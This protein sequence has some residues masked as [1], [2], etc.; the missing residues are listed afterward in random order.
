MQ[1][2]LDGPSADLQFHRQRLGV[3]PTPTLEEFE[4]LEGSGDPSG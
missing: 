1:I 2:P 3:M 4:Q